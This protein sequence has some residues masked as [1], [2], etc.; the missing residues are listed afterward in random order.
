[1][2]AWESARKGRAMGGGACGRDQLGSGIAVAAE[3]DSWNNF[4][5]GVHRD[6]NYKGGEDHL[7]GVGGQVA[8]GDEVYVSGRKHYEGRQNVDHIQ[9]GFVG[10]N[11]ADEAPHPNRRYMSNKHGEASIRAGGLFTTAAVYET[12]PHRRKGG[13]W[14]TSHDST[15][16]RTFKSNP[17]PAPTGQSWSSMYGINYGRNKNA[18]ED[19]IFNRKKVFHKDQVSQIFAK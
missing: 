8:G 6:A 17:P 9:L 11:L 18:V 10:Q 19:K 2:D 12:K 7:I 14:E 13:E 3:E 1:M 15:Y 4:G 5:R 16:H